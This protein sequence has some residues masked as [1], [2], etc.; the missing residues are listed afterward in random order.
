MTPGRWIEA[1]VA[2]FVLTAGWYFGLHALK[3][4]YGG[5]WIALALTVP[6]LGFLYT[7]ARQCRLDAD[8]CW[9]GF[10]RRI[11]IYELYQLLWPWAFGGLAFI[12]VLAYVKG[13]PVF[14]GFLFP[15]IGACLFGGLR[16]VPRA[17]ASL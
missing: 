8:G 2:G 7:L 16:N 14:W 11:H 17:P 10:G 5:A 3:I 1:T 15:V 6:A 9:N 4:G 12:G 13:A